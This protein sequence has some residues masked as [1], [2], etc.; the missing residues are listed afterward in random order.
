M[1]LGRLGS[2]PTGKLDE[3]SFTWHCSIW[4][5][6]VKCLNIQDAFL[7]LCQHF[8]NPII[9][10]IL[11]LLSNIDNLVCFVSLFLCICHYRFRVFS[12]H[13][14]SVFYFSQVVLLMPV[15]NC[16][17]K[18]PPPQPIVTLLHDREMFYKYTC[19]LTHFY[20]Q[21]GIISSCIF[22]CSYLG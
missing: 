17:A 4:L 21:R 6:Q 19:T 10:S 8:S 14:I 7:F 9:V 15:K 20:S 12:H 13:S 11:N 5:S 16:A 22:S 1:E 2:R 18:Y 3:H